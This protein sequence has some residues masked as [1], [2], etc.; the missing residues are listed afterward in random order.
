MAQVL[1]SGGGRL[2]GCM[3][4]RR[5]KPERPARV[6]K[7]A[8]VHFTQ[9]SAHTPD[10]CLGLFLH[11]S[12]NCWPGQRPGHRPFQI[13][14]VSCI[15]EETGPW[16]WAA[17]GWKAKEWRVPRQLGFPAESSWESQGSPL[18][19]Q[20]SA[21]AKGVHTPDHGNICHLFFARGRPA[22]GRGTG[23]SGCLES[24]IPRAGLP[25]PRPVRTLNLSLNLALGELG[26]PGGASCALGV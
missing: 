7:Q 25:L 22:T 23:W 11:D 5:G 19:S 8:P 21:T 15:V 17:G 4:C 10:S 1:L 20:R 18:L 9:L 26:L 12:L 14:K 16:H 24:V 2:V 6:V 3:P 13:P